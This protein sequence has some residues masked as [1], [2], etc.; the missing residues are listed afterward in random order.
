MGDPIARVQN[1]FPSNIAEFVRNLPHKEMTN[2]EFR[3]YMNNCKWGG[4]AFFRT[5]YQLA[6]QVGLY[7]IDEKSIY[8]PRFIRNI[9]DEEAA[10][11]LK[12]WFSRYYVP[13]PYTRGF[14]LLE[15]PVVV[16][17]S[18]YE[19]LKEEKKDNSIGKVCEEVFKESIGNPDIF[20]NTINRYS[21]LIRV[22]DNRFYIKEGGLL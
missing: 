15:K 4:N 5:Y 10:E 21:S 2:D 12:K 8:H 9:S 14:D 22:Q 6:C 17:Y 1:P 11:Y 18:I 19:Y 13:N 16:E 7:Y 3:I 20:I